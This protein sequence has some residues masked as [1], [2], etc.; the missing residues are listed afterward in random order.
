[1]YLESLD[2]PPLAFNLLRELRWIPNPMR[3]TRVILCVEPLNAK[4]FDL[5][6]YVCKP[7]DQSEQSTNL[8]MKYV[9]QYFLFVW[10]VRKL[11]ALIVHF[12]SS[13]WLVVK[14]ITNND[15]KEKNPKNSLLANRS[16]LMYQ[17]GGWHR[18][19]CCTNIWSTIS[20]F[21]VQTL[22]RLVNND[23][24]QDQ[25]SSFIPI[26]MDTTN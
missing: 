3:C 21:K 25:V 10:I 18:I 23:N 24:D 1:M 5:P 17:V 7:K 2:E 6:D 9:N 4:T 12:L 22:C 20:N 15:S 13:I 14:Y 16:Q 8:E 19:T 26:L 11:E